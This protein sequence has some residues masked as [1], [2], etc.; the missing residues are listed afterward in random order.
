MN[1]ISKQKFRDCFWLLSDEIMRRY[2]NYAI[3]FYTG[4]ATDDGYGFI[5]PEYDSGDGVHLNDKAHA[6]LFE[7][8]KEKVILE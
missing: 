1:F 2:G 7:R 8:V 4:I 3:D 6:E 5:K